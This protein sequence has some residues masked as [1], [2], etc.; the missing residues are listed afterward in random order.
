MSPPR[1]YPVTGSGHE[2]RVVLALRV[3]VQPS[4]IRVRPL[5]TIPH[6][7][8]VLLVGELEDG[9]RLDRG[10][11][12]LGP[13]PLHDLGNFGLGLGLDAVRDVQG[14][15]R[16][17]RRSLNV[18]AGLDGLQLL[19][20]PEHLASLALLAQGLHLAGREVRQGVGVQLGCADLLALGGPHMDT[21]GI[22]NVVAHFHDGAV[23]LLQVGGEIFTVE[24]PDHAVAHRAAATRHEQ[25]LALLGRHG[26]GL[27]AARLEILPVLLRAHAPTLALCRHG[28]RERRMRRG[29]VLFHAGQQLLQELRPRGEK[30][31]MP[32]P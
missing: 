23:E 25:I 17:G 15:V 31:R 30:G 12:L 19:A 20:Q 8:L 28:E 29:V 2:V 32:F 26:A 9:P 21:R 22:P 4:H 14:L 6:Q 27:P 3:A 24:E 10:R 1:R 7:P 11:L 16:D 13:R 18:C 5:A